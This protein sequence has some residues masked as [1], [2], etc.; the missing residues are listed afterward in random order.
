MGLLWKKNIRVTVT[1]ELDQGNVEEM[2]MNI[3]N[4]S[5]DTVGEKAQGINRVL[6]TIVNQ[7]E[8]GEKKKGGGVSEVKR[9]K[10]ASSYFF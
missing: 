1:L 5:L 7:Q 6:I 10:Y 2:G 9:E 8:E 3:A 4:L